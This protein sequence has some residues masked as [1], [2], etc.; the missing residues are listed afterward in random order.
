MKWAIIAL[1]MTS[2]I[3]SMMWVMPSP[4]QRFQSKLRMDAR[5]LGF[6][7][8][9]KH[10]KLPRG[11]GE[12]EGDER[13]LPLYRF[14]RT[15]LDRKEREQFAG[16]S[17]ARVNA[18]ANIGLPQGWSWIRGESELN[19]GRLKKLSDWLEGLPQEVIAVES[20]AHSLGLYWTEPQSEG[21]LDRLAALANK[22]VE[23]KL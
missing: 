20:E 18:L 7:V 10:L 1:I 8:S 22:A 14:A 4:R 16:W 23:E 3:G 21:A 15:N 9:L 17:V 5:K 2:L 13:N 11:Q 6:Q 19:S 12:T